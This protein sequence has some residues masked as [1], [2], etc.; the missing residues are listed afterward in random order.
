MIDRFAFV[1][2]AS[3]HATLVGRADTLARVRI[4]LA[5]LPGLVRLSLGTP[6]DASADKWDLAI[7]ARFADL[8][9]LTA[10]MSTVGWASIFDHMI[11]ARAAV[12][13]AWSFE[14]EDG[15]PTS[16]R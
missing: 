16:L 2:L 15:A 7:V 4:A 12:V 1:R 3:A 10:A 14:V 13:K 5:E 9:S 6:A 11:P 8:P